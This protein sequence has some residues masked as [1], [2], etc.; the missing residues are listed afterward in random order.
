[1]R[2]QSPNRRLAKAGLVIRWLTAR[3]NA[4][5][6]SFARNTLSFSRGAIGAAVIS[7]WKGAIAASSADDDARPAAGRL[8]TAGTV[9]IIWTSPPARCDGHHR[10]ALSSARGSGPISARIFAN[11]MTTAAA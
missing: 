8:G 6:G 1:M 3:P 11:T 10:N 2:D 4:M 7:S 5:Y 9:V